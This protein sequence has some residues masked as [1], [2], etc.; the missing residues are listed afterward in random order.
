M[1]VRLRVNSGRF[2][3]N[4]LKEILKYFAN[5]TFERDFRVDWPSELAAI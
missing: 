1:F 5:L 4:T 3:H 2:V